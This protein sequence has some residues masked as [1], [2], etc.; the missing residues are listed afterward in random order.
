MA[1]QMRE[2]QT[3]VEQLD[4]AA[5]Q[6]A[7]NNVIADRLALILV[8]NAVELLVYSRAKYALDW[9]ASLF[10]TQRKYFPQKRATVLGKNFCPK[11]QFIKSL[12]EMDEDEAE[13]CT[14][15]H[16][17]RNEA[18][19]V[20][21]RHEEVIREIAG[22]YFSLACDMLV[23]LRPRSC[24]IKQ[25]PQV[26]KKHLKRPNADLLSEETVREITSSLLKM[27]P[28]LN[29]SLPERMS[30]SAQGKIQQMR[31]GLDELA[32]RR[33]GKHSVADVIYELQFWHELYLDI[34]EGDNALVVN[35]AELERKRVEM[36]KNWRPKVSE[37]ALARWENRAKE[38]S[39][40][41]LP[42]RCL[43]KYSKILED[44]EEFDEL[45]GSA[46]I[47]ME[48]F[49]DA[50]LDTWRLQQKREGK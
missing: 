22:H 12:K 30:L 47:E 3:Y 16:E 28:E 26:L 39:K 6:L 24:E 14:Q 33:H 8:D 49:E 4:L 15:A 42:G 29:Y 35:E 44:T 11:V 19:H 31:D 10:L 45:V 32:L 23:R 27:C 40:E 38:L 18:Y 48:Q 20:G 7:E 2:L 50:L 34:P 41:A 1:L 5:R 25:L 46:W 37:V 21:I 9:D 13:F 36:S 43:Q 17:F